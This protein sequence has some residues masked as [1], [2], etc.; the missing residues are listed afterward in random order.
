MSTVDSTRIGFRDALL[1]LAGEREDVVFVSTDSL[2]VVKG[3]PFLERFP[4]RVVELGISEQNGVGVCSGLAASGLLPYICTYAGFLTMRACEQMRTFVSYPN[5]KVRFVGANGGLHGGNREGVSH[6]FI[7]DV[8]ILR[9]MPNFTIL[10]P[11]DGGQVYE[12]MLASVDVEGP[13]YIRIGSGREDKVFPDGT[14]FPLGKIRIL[15]DEGDDVALLAHGFVLGR[16]IEAAKRLK[17]EGIKAKVVEVATIKPLDREGLV[18]V[19][20]ATGCAVTV[21]DHTIINGLGS[22]VAEVIA[23]NVPAHLI[24]LGLQDVYGESGFPEEL[25]DAYGMRIEDIVSAA[26]KAVAH[27]KL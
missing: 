24:R 9:G 20:Q 17:A 18:A 19:L 22:A 10:C 27:K 14:P 16:V 23:E 4:D 6:Q 2:K 12:A 15:S 11:A 8:G 25:L 26:K 21:E 1:K 13:L 5:L 7:E 3:E